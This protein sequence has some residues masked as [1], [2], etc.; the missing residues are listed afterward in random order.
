MHVPTADRIHTVVGKSDE[1]GGVVF[2][3]TLTAVGAASTSE[4][5]TVLKFRADKDGNADGGD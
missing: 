2:P 5:I 4:I 1:V 3:R